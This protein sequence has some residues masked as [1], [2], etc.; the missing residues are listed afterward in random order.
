MGLWDSEASNEAKAKA[1][2]TQGEAMTETTPN[3]DVLK[4]RRNAFHDALAAIRRG[5]GEH[6]GARV[7]DIDYFKE[8]AVDAVTKLRND[9]DQVI[10]DAEKQSPKAKGA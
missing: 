4:A 8:I 6:R 1:K 2:A 3:L 7:A 9:M 5:F 10:R